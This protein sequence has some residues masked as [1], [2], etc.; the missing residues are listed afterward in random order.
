[1]S[2]FSSGMRS[3]SRTNTG[4][5]FLSHAGKLFFFL[6]LLPVGLT[7]WHLRRELYNSPL[8]PHWLVV[9]G[10]HA[11]GIYGRYTRNK[12]NFHKLVW[13]RHGVVDVIH[14]ANA[15]S[16]TPE[17]KA[18]RPYVEPALILPYNVTCL[19][20][21]ENRTV[22][23]REMIVSNYSQ[24]TEQFS[25]FWSQYLLRHLGL[26][27][28]PKYATFKKD[29]AA[30]MK[31]DKMISLSEILTQYPATTMVFI[32]NLVA[33][34]FCM[35]GQVPVSQVALLY[36]AFG[37]G[38]SHEVWRALTGTIAHFNA[39]HLALNLLSLT[40]VGRMV[41]R[42]IHSSKVSTGILFYAS[43]SSITFFLYNLSLIP[44]VTF[45]WWLLQG[46]MLKVLPTAA[47]RRQVSLPVV[48]YS[49]VL[50][51]WT[52][53]ASLEA[54]NMCLMGVDYEICFKTY[55]WWNGLV[56]FNFLPF[57]E[58]FLMHI[59]IPRSSFTGHL[60]GLLAGFLQ[61]WGLLPLWLL[62][63]A[64]SIPLL[65]WA[66]LKWIREMV[67]A[68][69]WTLDLLRDNS[70]KSKSPMDERSR[71][72]AF[73]L[74]Q[75]QLAT[76]VAS[77]WFFGLASSLTAIFATTIL[78]W[79]CLRHSLNLRTSAAPVFAKGYVVAAVGVLIFDAMTLGSWLA[80]SEAS[81][82]PVVVVIGRACIL[83]TCM[84]S[85]QEIIPA[86]P[87]GAMEWT[88]GYTTLQPCRELSR[89][90]WLT[91]WNVSLTTRST[92]ALSTVEM[93]IATFSGRGSRLG[94]H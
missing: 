44:I 76:L 14:I 30:A 37:K 72:W 43:F 41:E 7:Y 59:L 13:R 93:N 90:P 67:P 78:Y 64:L 20:G 89:H 23:D 22:C 6:Y 55:K 52:V 51:A 85:V 66:Y 16:T 79:H 83:L 10:K 62:Q 82:Y 34:A 12:G 68:T 8:V 60:A 80:V 58:L 35:D 46:A 54:D 45:L 49:G 87:S 61:Q 63:P 26:R 39:G 28:K 50:F 74:F 57:F 11:P 15:L 2:S 31:T 48:G 56:K 65:Y 36:D 5:D 1:M 19:R 53:I 25:A 29:K 9:S 4:E 81:F 47:T 32:V 73:V 91:Q 70:P 17:A 69:T 40:F 75:C 33:A 24:S 71:R 18:G 86:E 92:G 3:G 88:L 27:N 21:A 38:S 77:I 42:G 94:D 84:V